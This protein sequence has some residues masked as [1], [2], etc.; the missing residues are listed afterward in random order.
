MKKLTLIVVVSLFGAAFFASASS[1]ASDGKHAVVFTKDIAP[2]LQKHCEECHRQGGV[3][4]MSLVT[5]EEARPWARAIKERVS[6]R[7][8]PPFHA[9]GALGRYVGDPRLTDEEIATIS[10]WV[11]GGA[12]CGNPKDAPA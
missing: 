6:R 3:A 8:M 1:S 2:I 5:Y 9:T 7:E 10:N 4:P 12:T 11:D